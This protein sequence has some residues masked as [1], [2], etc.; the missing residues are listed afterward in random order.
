MVS[1]LKR[2]A[3]KVRCRGIH[4]AKQLLAATPTKY[5]KLFDP[6]QEGKRSPLNEVKESL[7]ATGV[8]SYLGLK[9]YFQVSFCECL[10]R[11]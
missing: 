11:S 10:I 1:T 7:E 3:H 6:K 9:S 4:I 8:D 5:V 2:I